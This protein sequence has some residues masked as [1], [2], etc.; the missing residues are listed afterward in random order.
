V[1]TG[2]RVDDAG[3]LE[4]LAPF[5]GHRQRVVRLIGLSGQRKQAFGPRLAPMDHRRR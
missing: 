4:L 1:L 3:M 5:T 2:R